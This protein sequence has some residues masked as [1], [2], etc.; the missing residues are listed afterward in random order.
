M[1]CVCLLIAL[2]FIASSDAQTKVV[3][4]E[5][6]YHAPSLNTDDEFIELFNSGDNDIDVS[7][8][9]FTDGINYTFPGGSIIEGG[10]YLVLSPMSTVVD[11]QGNSI[12]SF[13]IYSGRLSNEGEQLALVDRNGNLID[14]FFYKEEELWPS[15]ADGFGPSVERIHPDMAS[16]HP[17]TWQAGPRLGTPGRPNQ[18]RVDKPIP[19]VT[20]IVQFPVTPASVDPV[21]IGCKII[22]PHPVTEV[23][24]HYK[25]ETES[26]YTVLDLYDDGEHGDGAAG[27]M[28]F[29]G[30]I[31]PHSH[32]TIIEFAIEAMDGDS[33][34]GWFPRE[35][36]QQ[37]VIYRVDD[38]TY[39]DDLPVYRIVM[40]DR[41]ETIL[42][43]R[44]PGSNDELPASFVS[45]DFIVYNVGVRFRGKGSRGREPKSY[46]VNFSETKH[47]GTIRKLN[48]NAVEIDRQFIGL[49]CFRRLG[50]PVPEKQFVSVLFN[51]TFVHNY[52]QVERT[53]KMMM[54]RIFGNG[55]G[56]LY[57]GIEQANFDFRGENKEAYRANY[58][59]ETN[60]PEDDYSDIVELCRAFSA[61]ADDQF[62]AALS[63]VI[64]IR[65][66]IRWFALKQVLND[67]EGGLSK[68]RGDDYFIYHNPEDNLFYLLPWD[69]DSVVIEPISPI[70][71]HGTVAVQRLLRH[72]DLARFYYE[73]ILDIVVN[74]LTQEVV[75]SIIDQTAPVS[76]LQR[77]NQLKEIYR[78]LREFHIQS[79]PQ[80][81]SYSISGN[82]SATIVNSDDVWRFFRGTREPSS[83]WRNIDFDDSAWEEGRGGFGYG[84]ND[85]TTVLNDMQNRYS[86]VYIR[87]AIDIP[88]PQLIERLTLTMWYDDAFIAYLNG[89]EIARSNVDGQ[90]RFNSFASGNH[91]VGNLEEFIVS[92]PENLLVAGKNVLALIGLNV[93]LNSSD[94]S[95]SASLLAKAK[96]DESVELIGFADASKTR[97]VHIN[98]SPA[99][100]EPWKAEWKHIVFLQP[101]RN[102]IHIE[103]LNANHTVVD[104]TRFAIYKNA[105]P[106]ADGREILGYEQWTA[107]E[108]PIVVDTHIIVP[109]TDTLII[110]AGA[111]IRMASGSAFI[112][113]G[114]MAVEGTSENPVLFQPNQAEVLWGGIVADQAK[115][116]LQIRHASFAGTKPFNFRNRSYP[117]VVNVRS[118]TAVIENCQFAN[119]TGLGIQTNQSIVTLR[120][121]EFTSM[122]EMLHCI[123][124]SALVEHNVFEN[125]LGY[126]DAIDFDGEM[127][128]PPSVIRNNTIRG[129]EDDGIDT[130]ESSVLIENNFIEGCA[131][132]GISL[133]GASHPV[134]INNVLLHCDIGVAV[135]DQCQA[136]IYHHTIVS[137]SSGIEVYEKN[138]QAG[139]ASAEI[140]NSVIWNT[141]NSVLFDEKSTVSI[142]YSNLMRIPDGYLD[143]NLSLDPL[144]VD[145]ENGD[146]RLTSLSPMIDRLEST[147]IKYD[148]IGQIRPTGIASDIGAYE[149]PEIVPIPNWHLY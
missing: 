89:I 68:E 1:N 120:G 37:S 51:D 58:Q 81:I 131:D 122:G 14:G 20:N 95:L 24:L 104:A 5:F 76:T 26:T 16:D 103:A 54:E 112:V 18:S 114:T 3:I 72:P 29:G 35:G 129:S 99:F 25:T 41:H 106:P 142:Q 48:L 62:V 60:E 134:L 79:I 86:T 145:E 102:V 30:E 101:G 13:G 126:N 143:T 116:T 53:D 110:D 11:A 123:N 49:E 40:R 75:E 39:P 9:R 107:A 135:K 78:K 57:R 139:G 17:F 10:G 2:L 46:R 108:N 50:L 146:V 136:K 47:F 43:T 82:L 71:H 133:E 117:A 52:L 92:N 109:S 88:D 115:G 23:L 69:L 21:R 127:P 148:I 6:M 98:G 140:L 80:T 15:S 105:S 27:D 56:N 121:S 28:V 124:S 138:A 55:D 147:E 144:F 130:F 97:W 22:H 4:N 93:S 19:I 87:K 8:W 66:W 96:S 125:V 119:V 42:R 128:E 118:S 111:D 36:L 67:L 32:N 149:F 77:R 12:Q 59:K 70:H 85:D 33:V 84:D 38:S 31:P 74:E 7:G 113:Y 141:E 44:N 132:K 34:A 100:Y 61:T 65:Q 45:N 73:D 91:E 137:C 83:G 90:P 94:F 64:H 63:K